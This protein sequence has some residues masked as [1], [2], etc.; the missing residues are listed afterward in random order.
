MGVVSMLVGLSLCW[1]VCWLG[2][3]LVCA[4]VSVWAVLR[5]GETSFYPKVWMLCV[6]CSLM[7]LMEWSRTGRDSG[8]ISG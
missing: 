3:A 8:V 1:V 2:E 5:V 4:W 7:G 6:Y